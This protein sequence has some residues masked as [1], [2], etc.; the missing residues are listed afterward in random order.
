MLL[1]AVLVSVT[2]LRD[3]GYRRRRER[4]WPNDLD[5]YLKRYPRPA[6]LHAFVCLSAGA[7]LTIGVFQLV[8]PD[9]AIARNG[10]LGVLTL[11]AAA[12]AVLFAS[13]RDWSPT[14][15]EL[16]MALITA[17]AARLSV[18]FAGLVSSRANAFEYADRLPVIFNAVVFAMAIMAALWF[19]M[20]RFWDQ[21]LLDGVPWTTTGRMIP[22]ARRTGFVVAAM[23]V[24]AAFQLAFWPEWV[25]SEKGDASVSRTITAALASTLLAWV[26]AQQ[27]RRAGSP[28][29]AGLAAAA[30]LATIA[31]VLVRATDSPIRAWLMQYNAIA[32]SLSCLPILALAEAAPASRW[33]AFANP[34]WFLALLILP[35][36]ALLILAGTS[37]FPADWVRPLT[38]VILCGV[39]IL[40]GTREGRRAFLI[41]GGTIG[42]AAL[43]TFLR[44]YGRSWI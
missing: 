2:I 38:L 1:S 17:G 39:Y 7:I 3:L 16:G 36:A 43:V 5:A 24:L 40:A 37:R 9:P 33:R 44:T 10:F 35:A 12:W 13:Y 41:L 28:M 14:L 15:S 19:W 23:G 29:M 31:I 11:G 26:A 6:A 22:L 20:S 32:L 21:Q 42:V 4:A 25:P 30:L 27:A 8:R 34:L 18:G